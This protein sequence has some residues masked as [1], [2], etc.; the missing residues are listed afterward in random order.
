MTGVGDSSS[1]RASCPAELYESRGMT[2]YDVLMDVHALF[3]IA[4]FT[5]GVL[6]SVCGAGFISVVGGGGS[7]GPPACGECL[8]ENA[9]AFFLSRL[10][11]YMLLESKATTRSIQVCTHACGCIYESLGFLTTSGTPVLCTHSFFSNHACAHVRVA[12][13]SLGQ[14]L[15]TCCSSISAVALVLYA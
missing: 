1:C 10:F 3:W 12:Q 9:R 4:G 7:R 2:P 6:V 8:A 15:C 5:S 11:W 14:V 13:F